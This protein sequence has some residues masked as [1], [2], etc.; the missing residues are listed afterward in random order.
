M[1]SKIIYF[2]ATL[3][4][5]VVITN[6]QAQNDSDLWDKVDEIRQIHFADT[7]GIPLGTIDSTLWTGVHMMGMEYTSY[8]YEA[9]TQLVGICNPDFRAIDF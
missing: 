3:L 8:E 1:K 2:F 6:L 5:T 9:A 4:L 7:Y